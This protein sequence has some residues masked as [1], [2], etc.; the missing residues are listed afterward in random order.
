MKE[1][2]LHR[3]SNS[4]QT[5]GSVALYASPSFSSLYQE[6][7]DLEPGPGSYDTPVAL[8]PQFVSTRHSQPS[9]SITAKHDE[10]WSK[11]MITK[12]HLMS[13][14]ARGTPG[15]GTY[16]PGFIESQASV[17]IGSAKRR[18]LSDTH[19]K[20]PGPIYDVLGNPENPKVNIRF[21]KANRFDGDNRSMTS[22]LGSTG[23]GQ[24]EV[25]GSFDGARL[26]KSFGASHRA[27]DKVRFPGS[28]KEGMGR[29]SPGPGAGLPFQNTGHSMSFTRAERLPE[30]PTGK[31]APGPGAYDNHEKPDPSV[32]SRSVYSFGKPHARSRLDWKQMRH[33]NNT[34]WGMR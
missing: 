12:D 15:P 31:R 16:I 11:V 10:A 29:I 6:P 18:G 33:L 23:P 30:D 1:G 27:Y 28:E 20:A 14:M 21:S 19:F 5:S 22:V 13:L 34:L 2:S 32:K 9:L 8:G 24:Y 7:K 25:S 4:L 17:S 26:A 3:T